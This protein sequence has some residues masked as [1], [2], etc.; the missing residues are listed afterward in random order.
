[1]RRSIRISGAVVLWLGVIACVGCGGSGSGPKL[2]P[3]SGTV[4]CDNKPLP[5]GTIY[6]KTLQ[7]GAFEEIPIKDGKFEGRAAEGERRVEITAYR[8]NVQDFDGMKGEVKESLIPEN[9]N[10]KSTLAATVTS[11]GPNTFTFDVKCKSPSG[12]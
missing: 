7:T 8:T 1:M 5:E 4:T 3:V 10:V 11:Q 12:K 6:F 9:F 2:L